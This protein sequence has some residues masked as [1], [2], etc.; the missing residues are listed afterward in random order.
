MDSAGP[1][2]TITLRLPLKRAR[3][4]ARFL[5]VACGDMFAYW[6]A[7]GYDEA[8]EMQTAAEQIREQFSAQ[9]IRPAG[10]GRE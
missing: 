7:K 2:V 4:F 10:E 9:G 3:L 5:A 1:T 8:D 6:G